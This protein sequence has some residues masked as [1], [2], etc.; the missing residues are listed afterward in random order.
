M[1]ET[2]ATDRLDAAYHLKAR[3]ASADGA[4][5]LLGV[6]GDAFPVELARAA[7]FMALDVGAEPDADRSLRSDRVAEFIE[8]F[9]DERARRFLHRL[10]T[11]AF[12]NFAG[13]VF[14]RDDA[15]AHL[16]FL[17]AGELRRQAIGVFRP[18]LLLWNLTH[19]ASPAVAK[20]N[21][22][23][24]QVLEDR[25]RTLGG[26]R[27][28]AAGL[29]AAVADERGRREALA[30]LEAL[31]RNG[32]VSGSEMLRWRN[33]GRYMSAGRHAEL[34]FDAASGLAGRSPRRGARLG[35]VGSG[36]DQC[37]LYDMLEEFG[38][39]VADPHPLGSAWPHPRPVT[40]S[41]DQIVAAVASNP[42]A[43]RHLPVAQH[44]AA[45]VQAC[46]EAGSEIVVAQLDENDDTFGWDWPSIRADL[47]A[48]GTAW[49]ELGFRPYLPDEGWVAAARAKLSAAVEA[50]TCS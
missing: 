32:I 3:G 46:V 48:N 28:E 22:A 25:L 34:L 13:I 47:E 49:L 4:K 15:A 33:A 6:F 10:S 24:A 17:Y 20:F 45:I 36:I 44:R 29:G 50:E 19:T 9:V 37:W 31:R 41:L 5:P 14:S 30:G 42:L 27:W 23:E 43:P 11:G 26:R 2:S 21:L 8:P 7:G 18:E 40:D 35:L 12:D 1:N 16:A 39:V 38:T